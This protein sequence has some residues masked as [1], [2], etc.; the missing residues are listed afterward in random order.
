MMLALLLFLKG[1]E[2]QESRRHR[3]ELSRVADPG[4]G[5]FD[6]WKYVGG[7]RVCFDPSKKKISQSFIQNCCWITLHFHIIKDERLVL[8][9]EGKAN[10]WVTYRLSGTRI[11]ECLEI[12]DVEYNLKHFDGSTRLTLT[13]AHILRQIYATGAKWHNHLV[14]VM[15]AFS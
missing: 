8:K 5:G 14:F 2:K 6:P 15:T 13:R 11:V 3:N 7:V 4:I 10:F 12:I 9:L 1:L